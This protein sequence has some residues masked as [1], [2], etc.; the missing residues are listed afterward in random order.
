MTRVPAPTA[1]Y[2]GTGHSRAPS[3]AGVRAAP[4]ITQTGPATAKVSAKTFLEVPM[5]P[6]GR[7][8]RFRPAKLGETNSMSVSINVQLPQNIS[9]TQV[10]ILVPTIRKS[11]GL[12]S[13]RSLDADVCLQLPLRARVGNGV[14]VRPSTTR[15]NLRM[16]QRWIG[17]DVPSARRHQSQNNPQQSNK[18]QLE[19]LPSRRYDV[20]V[21]HVVDPVIDREI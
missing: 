17:V 10:A 3:R 15:W 21:R 5:V 13:L 8:V 11:D 19:P 6:K 20:V 2:A 9:L 4:T 7:F 12:Y 18:I 16:D 1:A 14:R